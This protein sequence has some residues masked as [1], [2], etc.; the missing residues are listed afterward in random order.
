MNKIVYSLVNYCKQDKYGK[1]NKLLNNK[2]DSLTWQEYFI[3]SSLHFGK[4]NPDKKSSYT[5][6]IVEILPNSKFAYNN[7]KSS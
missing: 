3:L 5:K 7:A 2:K 6:K 1:V 4:K